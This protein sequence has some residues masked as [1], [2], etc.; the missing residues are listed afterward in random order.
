MT[1]RCIFFAVLILTVSNCTTANR[2]PN[3]AP[4]KGTA[5]SEV[6]E[7][8]TLEAI[9]ASMGVTDPETREQQLTAYFENLCAQDPENCVDQV[10]GK[11]IV[12]AILLK[13]DGRFF[14]DVKKNGQ[15]EYSCIASPGMNS[16]LNIDPEYG[17]TPIVTNVNPKGIEKVHIVSDNKSYAGAQMPWTVWVLGSVAIHANKQA[18]GYRRSHGCI[19]LQQE[20]AERFFKDVQKVGLRRTFITVL[21][22]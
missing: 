14:L 22:N 8:P 16:F 21:E 5:Q 10:G 17:R 13:R 2:A 6:N 3:S 18:N 11:D 15:L 7:S 4:V 19:N 20:C 12:E 1:S 9:E